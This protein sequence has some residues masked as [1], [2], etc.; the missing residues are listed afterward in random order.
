MITYYGPAFSFPYASAVDVINNKTPPQY[1][2]GKIVLIGS[3]VVGI[4]D[5]H[6]TPLQ[7]AGYPGVEIHASMIESI[8]NQDIISS[9]LWLNGAERILLVVLGLMFTILAAGFSIFSLFLLTAGM[10]ATLFGFNTMLLL[11]WHLILPHLVLPY[12]QLLFL[13]IINGG[14][15]YF[16]EEKTRKKLHTFYGQYVSATHIDKILQLHDQPTLS[17]DTKNMTVLF[18][19]VGNFTSISEKL[20]AKEVK[21]FLNTLFTPLTKLIFEY[22]GTIDKYVGDMIIAFWNDPIDDSQHALHGVQVALMMQNKVKELAPV[23]AKQK[24]ANVGIRIGINTGMMHVGDMGSEYRKAYTVLGDAVNLASRLEG[25]NKI[26]KTSIL[27]SQATKDRCNEILFRFVDHIYVKGKATPTNIYEPLCLL[28]DK[29][30]A[31]ETELT[32]YEKALKLYNA[33]NW[34]NAKEKFTQLVKQYPQIEIYAIYLQRV[35]QK[36]SATAK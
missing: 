21:K 24:L 2:A 6:S 4:G 1:F 5:S 16:F 8:L 10:I 35:R 31:L 33:E 3:S 23:F 32:Q 12:L 13:G 27:V 17:G 30:V 28:K 29:T 36:L 14:Y 15:G 25:V 20:D 7:S 22:K 34:N 26:Y 11:K 18:A 19:D 9:P